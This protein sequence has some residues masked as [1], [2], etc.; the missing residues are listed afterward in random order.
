MNAREIQDAADKLVSEIGPL[1]DLSFWVSSKSQY[2]SDDT[3]KTNPVTVML[4]PDG[5]GSDA[6]HLMVHE[7]TFELA[8][9]AIRAKWEKY[10]AVHKSRII[11][12]MALAIIEI[13][14]DQG[15]CSEAALRSA[16]FSDE[17]I[18]FYGAK[19]AAD[20]DEI[21][22]GGPFKI[23]P[24]ENAN[25]APDNTVGITDSDIPF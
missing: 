11:R 24:T 19:A 10:S 5:T 20:A 18:K 3:E 25:G 22:A 8:F 21:A 12:K 13:T 15:A 23:V 16:K 14:A 7:K 4:Y 17:E 1:A 6:P 2:L 9:E